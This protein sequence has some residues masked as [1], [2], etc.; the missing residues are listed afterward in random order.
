MAGPA[1]LGMGQHDEP[2]PNDLWFCV[3]NAICPDSRRYDANQLPVLQGQ[4]T[5]SGFGPSGIPGS[6]CSLDKYYNRTF[7]Q[8]KRIIL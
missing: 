1:C 3:L 2:P 5:I 7:H 4:E 8:Y 6:L